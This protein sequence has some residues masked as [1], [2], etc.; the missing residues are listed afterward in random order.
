MFDKIRNLINRNRK[1]QYDGIAVQTMFHWRT[2]NRQE[3]FVN[4]IMDKFRR[5]PSDQQ[6][7]FD[8]LMKE[9]RKRNYIKD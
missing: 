7:D 4:R 6:I 3:E 1:A 8:L 5:T 2:Q 9:G